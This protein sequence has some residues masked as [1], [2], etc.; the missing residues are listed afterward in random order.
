MLNLRHHLMEERSV[1]FVVVFLLCLGRIV[2][3]FH[4]LLF[5]QL[6]KFDWDQL[7][8]LRQRPDFA[9]VAGS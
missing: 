2:H 5:R 1:C 8:H 3:K 4:I 6:P 7:Y 9:A